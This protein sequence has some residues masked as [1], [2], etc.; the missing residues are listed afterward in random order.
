LLKKPGVVIARN[1]A[2][3]IFVFFAFAIM[4][5]ISYIFV[6]NIA[7]KQIFNNAE[8]VLETAEIAIRTDLQKA[9]VVLLS[10]ELF[11][12]EALKTGKSISEIK[13]YIIR[14]TGILT[15]GESQDLGMVDIYCY[16]RGAFIY[17]TDWELPEDYD[18]LSRPW[19]TAIMKTKGAIAVTD[20]Y[21]DQDTGK[22]IITLGKTFKLD[23]SEDVGAIALDIDFSILSQYIKSLQF[24]EGGYGMLVNGSYQFIV[25]PNDPYLQNSMDNISPGLMK[26]ADEFRKNGKT[27][28]SAKM[29]N[30]QGVVMEV[31]FRRIYNG[32]LLGI[33]S[34]TA[35]YYHDVYSMALVLSTL[36]F[37]LMAI[38]SVILIRLNESRIQSEEENKDKSSF[39]ARMSH[40][41][42]TPMNTILG[43]TELI[44]RKNV[45][46]E[47]QEYI[48]MIH[49]AGTNLLAIINDILDFSKIESGRL[50]I[51]K[52]NYHIASV[53]NDVINLIRPR[54]SDKS[55]DF[56][57]QVN[58]AIP[59]ELGGD[60][61]RLRQILTNLLTNAVKYTKKGFVLLSVDMEPVDKRT[62]R[63]ICT[64]RD[65]GIGIKDEDMG[66]LFTDFTRLDSHSNYGVEGT[67]L[68]LAI[69]RA[70][71]LS[72]GGDITVSS[73]YGAGSVFRAT[74]TQAVEQDD[75]VAQVSNAGQKKAL[76]FDWRPMHIKGLLDTFKSLDV[77]VVFSET[78]QD[79]ME[80]MEQG[81]YGY[82]F[83]SSKYAMDCMYL[84]G[85]RQKPLQMVIMVEPGEMAVFREVSSIMMPVYSV[86]LAHILNDNADKIAYH[87]TSP[88]I[89]FTAPE[90]KILIVDDISTN[91]RVAK[92]L[93]APYNM[94]I[95]TCLSGADAVREVVRNHYD[96]VFM[97]HMMPEMDGVEATS[98]IRGM[99][100]DPYYKNLPVIM[101]TANAVSGQREI[102]LQNGIDDFLAK[103][104]DT[105]KLNDCL[106]KWLPKEKI[107]DAARTEAG[108][109]EA[110][111]RQPEL[112]VSGIDVGTGLRNSGGSQAAY[113]DILLDFCR[114][115][116]TRSA[117][118]NEALD[119]G[120]IKLYITLVHALKG[121]ARS[122]GATATGEL[123]AWLE[124][125]AKDGYSTEIKIKTAELLENARALAGNIKAAE[126]RLAAA[127]GK[128]RAD[129]SALSLDKFKAALAGMDIEEVNKMLIE[130]AGLSLDIE[131]KNKIAEVEECILMFEYDKAI[132]KINKFF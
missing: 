113:L 13:S 73:K 31:V 83:I 57:V 75:P 128:P 46:S 47:V 10:S 22:A 100:D 1:L 87:S 61:M 40:E 42:R 118:I 71:C 27:V 70:L 53:I 88:K 105:Q 19:Y 11:I 37:T 35:T 59:V 130:Y 65:S 120:D 64:V 17:G 26:I 90:A 50:K 82:A 108:S 60:D 62:I 85:K 129:L 43:M 55:L 91:L 74:I 69:T 29:P 104:I 6:S 86:T 121:A 123:A 80:K 18:P 34:P 48:D 58:P 109:E 89:R 33:A 132:E 114:D 7:E 103:P 122:I 28:I 79:F 119:S 54:A 45:S 101:L 2:Q 56:F 111:P 125:A 14:E 84:L 116:E 41:I 115:A 72:M 99:D 38:L 8:K 98:L 12:K 39:L 24:T 124:D 117:R 20:P 102:F 95:H 25:H 77:A 106:E 93:M 110:P 112:A 52:R 9:E 21:I 44:Q 92:E 51:E 49:H 96:L 68:G 23:E 78:L 15:P 30:S 3:V 5:L 66:R 67:G 36:G 127:S 97:D 131:T 107:V 4:V 63:L 32:W 16:F 126:S 76:L 81:D 94:N